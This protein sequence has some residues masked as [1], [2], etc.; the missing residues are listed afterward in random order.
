MKDILNHLKRLGE[1]VDKNRQQI[2][3]FGKGIAPLI[4]IYIRIYYDLSEESKFIQQYY[5]Q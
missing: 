1:L 3:K 5:C 2:L 4:E